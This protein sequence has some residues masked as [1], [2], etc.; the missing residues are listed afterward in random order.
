MLCT[1]VRRPRSGGVEG[2]ARRGQGEEI[3]PVRLY[4]LPYQCWPANCGVR[5]GTAEARSTSRGSRHQ[6]SGGVMDILFLCGECNNVCP[7]RK[8]HPV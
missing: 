1:A 6:D 7:V 4:V 2:D 8:A 5:L 3:G